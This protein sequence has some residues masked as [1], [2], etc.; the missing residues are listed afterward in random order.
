MVRNP[1]IFV[2]LEN[3]HLIPLDQW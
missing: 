3:A 2:L 1:N